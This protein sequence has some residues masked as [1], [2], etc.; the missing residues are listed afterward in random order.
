VTE[1]F[2]RFRAY[3]GRDSGLPG[4]VGGGDVN[5]W[6]FSLNAPISASAQNG[7]ADTPGQ[8]VEALD[9]IFLAPGKDSDRDTI[10]HEVGHVIDRHFRDDYSSTFEGTEVQEGLANMFSYD[11]SYTTDWLHSGLT[12]N[13][14]A[15][16]STF[17]TL[18]PDTHIVP[19]RM[20][21]YSCAATDP[22][23]NSFILTHAYWQWVND[24]N[25]DG[26]DGRT[27]AGRLLQYVPYQL[28]GQRTFG[29]TRNAF[30]NLIRN[31]YGTNSREFDAYIQAFGF[32][33]NILFSDSRATL[34]PRGT[35]L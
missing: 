5:R 4:P 21:G 14:E 20:N 25:S 6:F 3:C 26:L 15:A 34:C 33:T 16:G 23:Y 17:F 35:T 11:Y 32:E 28:A 12:I 13:E 9:R 31:W 1:F 2:C 8:Y 30:N 10:A 19:L 29:D 24:M 7:G 18:P 22:H 27:I